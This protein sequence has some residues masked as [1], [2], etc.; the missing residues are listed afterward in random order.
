MCALGCFIMALFHYFVLGM[1]RWCLP[2]SIRMLIF[3]R[4]LEHIFLA[5]RRDDFTKEIRGKYKE[6]KEISKKSKIYQFCSG[7]SSKFISL[8]ISGM[9]TITPFKSILPKY[10]LFPFFDSPFPIPHSSFQDSPFRQI[11]IAQTEPVFVED[12]LHLVVCVIRGIIWGF[13]KMR[14]RK[15]GVDQRKV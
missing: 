15:R 10:L 3:G 2:D 13:W 1:H 6:I 7:F 5:S 8:L 14:V 4:I 11:E 12:V 9:G